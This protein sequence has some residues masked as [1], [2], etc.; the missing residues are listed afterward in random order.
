MRNSNILILALF[1]CTSVFGQF[2]EFKLY[3]IGET[4]EDLL[5][6]T[7]LADIDNDG[8]M[9][10]VVGSNYGT[11]WWFEYQDA[12]KWIKHILGENAITFIGG[13]AYDVNGDGLTDQVSGQ[14]W[15]K[16]TGNGNFERF[17]NGAII[18]YDNAHADLDGDGKQDMIAVS[19][20]D[21]LYWY[22]N[23]SKPEKKWKGY[24]IDVGVPGG[25][26]NEA[27]G[28]L[29]GDMK[30]DIVR[31]NAWYEN[32]GDPGKWY[33]HYSFEIGANV[34]KYVHSLRAW[35]ADMDK[36]GDND[37]ILCEMNTEN[38]RIAWF[39]N[40]DMKGTNWY[41]HTIDYDTQQ[42]F[43]SL[44]VCD[45]DNDGD[46]DVFSGG[47]RFTKDF[48]KRCYIWENTDGAATTWKKHEILVDY[49][50]H[51]ARAADVDGDGDIDICTKP[52]KGS[53]KNIYLRNMLIENK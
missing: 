52:W 49:E 42:D 5:G 41:M 20:E 11:I 38:A 50:S 4:E 35:M 9:D 53:T 17:E 12:G 46:L 15:F 34:G 16:N 6:Q 45:F 28:D 30:P 2:P 51:E 33:V 37:V 3:E 48:H 25:I 7:S 18:A 21:G 14:T 43:H 24:K 13:T 27:I 40:K 1:I 10:W 22:P 44:A 31:S 32:T 8:D 29:N 19:E 39:E 47:A 36:D 26:S 23:P